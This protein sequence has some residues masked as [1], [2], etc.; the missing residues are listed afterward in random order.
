MSESSGEPKMNQ[1]EEKHIGL[2]KI[3]EKARKSDIS[4]IKNVVTGIIKLINDPD[5]S[6]KDFKEIIQIDPPLTGKLLQL[7]NSAYY[8]PGKK[9]FEIQQAMIWVGFDTLK[10]LAIRQKVCEVFKGNSSIEGFSRNALW[11]HCVAVALLGKLIYRREFGKKGENIYVAGLLHDIGVIALEQFCKKDFKQIISKTKTDQR[12]QTE[13]E[14]ELLGFDHAKIG[15]GIAADWDLPRELV[16]I[17]G[18]HHD[19]ETISHEFTRIGSTLYVA[20]YICQKKH[21]GYQ[22]TPILDE[23]RFKKCLKKLDLKSF[24]LDLIVTDVELEIIKMEEQGLL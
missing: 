10:E 13:I 5:S 19:P 7:A 11:K 16:E 22:N 18:G 8:A 15:R 4:S 23:V 17:I 20:D 24:A 6:A 21:V 2:K 3:L 12:N 9:I 14:K 1:K